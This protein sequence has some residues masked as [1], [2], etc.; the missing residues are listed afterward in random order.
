M[1]R[2]F[3]VPVVTLLSAFCAH[4]ELERHQYEGAL[5]K[6]RVGMTVVRDGNKIEGGHYFYQQFLKDIAITGA[7]ENYQVTLTETGGGTFHLH[8]VGN[9]SDGGRPL[10]FE[11]S[12]GLDG[13][14]TSAD[15]AS[16]NPVTLRGTTI[17]QGADD[18]SQYRDITN[19]GAEAFETRVQTFWRA[20]LRGD[21]TT[22]VRFISYPL[23]VNVAKGKSKTY[24]NAPPLCWLRGTSFSLRP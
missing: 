19:E 24:R 7:F 13:T 2:C 20:V 14:W 22:A 4:G 15:G 23:Q 17:R 5:G 10:D 3:V 6:S 8:F 12:I 11:N 21:K 1:P 18:G 9:G 16:T